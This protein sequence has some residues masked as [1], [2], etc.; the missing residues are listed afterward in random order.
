MSGELRADLFQDLLPGQNGHAKRHFF[1]GL[2]WVSL[3][4]R[5]WLEY[6]VAVEG[7]EIRAPEWF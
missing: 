4:G 1:A 7:S 5:K 3:F 6:L 2:L